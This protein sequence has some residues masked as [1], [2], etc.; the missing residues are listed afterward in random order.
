[1]KN[2]QELEKLN[3]E[4][5]KINVESLDSLEQKSTEIEKVFFNCVHEAAEEELKPDS[6]DG[7][8]LVNLTSLFRN[9]GQRVLNLLKIE[10][11]ISFAGVTLIHFQIPKL[12]NNKVS[13][14]KNN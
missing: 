13:T 2:L 10:L 12:E 8:K 9:L 4:L 14:S 7:K 3:E 11:T 5:L 1:M 6:D